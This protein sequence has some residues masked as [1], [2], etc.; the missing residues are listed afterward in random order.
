MDFRANG[1]TVQHQT[2][3]KTYR[4]REQEATEQFRRDAEVMAAQGYHPVSQTYAPGSYGCMSF[5][6]ALALCL[7]LIGLLVFVYMIIVK[8]AGALT[9]T[10]AKVEQPA[11][12][13]CSTKIC[14]E[15][16]ETVK[17]A[18]LKCRFC[19]FVFPEPPSGQYRTFEVAEPG[20]ARRLES[21]SYSLGRQLGQIWAKKWFRTV[22]YFVI[23]LY[24]LGTV[25]GMIA[26]KTNP[27]Q[28]VAST[29]ANSLTTVTPV[30]APATAVKVVQTQ[31]PVYTDE[32]IVG[33]IK[34]SQDFRK[35]RAGYI[36][37]VRATLKAGKCTLAHLRSD[38][39]WLK[40]QQ[41][42]DSPVY[43]LHCGESHRDHR[44]YIDLAKGTW[45][46]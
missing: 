23:G 32:E 44:V 10:Y 8:P 22:A 31:D 19:G 2:M 27:T 13:E 3:I 39:F 20:S 34:Q 12:A 25:G 21:S 5:L 11:A 15:C 37:A 46:Q 33:L 43:F 24:A 17:A 40:S 7:I 9:V 6:V 30:S 45:F 41:H 42:P 14:P 1:A 16:A 4:G 26:P 35:H 29:A 38:G 18:A 36:K 28:V